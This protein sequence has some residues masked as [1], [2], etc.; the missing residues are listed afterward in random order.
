M[1]HRPW[2]QSKFQ[3]TTLLAVVALLVIVFLIS[4]YFFFTAPPRDA[5][6]HAQAVLK[7][8]DQ[9]ASW[10]SAKPASFRYVVERDCACALTFT[11]PY[12]VF[13]EHGSRSAHFSDLDRARLDDETAVP[14]DPVWIDG[15]FESI[16]RSI[17]EGIELTI[18]YDPRYGY[19]SFVGRV[20][21]D[22]NEEFLIYVRDFEVLEY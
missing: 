21:D 11:T 3:L 9:R 10:E 16:E 2:R 18:R 15:L 14:A 17:S 19:P 6:E 7:L 8:Q 1:K 22:S 5:E 4:A 12:I 20:A 13:E